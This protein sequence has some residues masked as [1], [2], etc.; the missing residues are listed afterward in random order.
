MRRSK[1]AGFIVGAVA[2]LSG[3]AALGSAVGTAQASAAGAARTCRAWT[4]DHPPYAVWLS[5]VD[6]L[7]PCDI[8]ATGIPGVNTQSA[9]VTDLLHWNGVTWTLR[10]SP[11]V[12]ASLDPPPAVTATSDRDV[13]I[14]GTGVDSVGSVQ[15]LIAHWNGT[16]LSRAASPNPGVPPGGLLSGV[17][18]AGPDDAWAVGLYSV[19]STDDGVYETSQTYPLAA[20]W[21]GR[22]WTQV[23]AAQPG[24]GNGNPSPLAEFNAVTTVGGSDAWAVGSDWVESTPVPNER[25]VPLAERWN[26]RAWQVLSPT[27]ADAHENQL[28]A[29]SAAGPND[30]W[31]VGRYGDQGKT[32]TEHWNGVRWTILPSPSPGR[33]DGKPEGVLVGVAVVSARDAWAVGSYANSPSVG[34][35]LALVLHWNGSSWRQVA[36]PHYGPKGSPNLLTAV[37]ASSSGNV[38]AVGYYSGP[39]GDGQQALVLR[40]P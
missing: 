40:L 11:A 27:P 10:T 1:A 34:K 13:W 7:S 25:Q 4:G 33:V 16:A 38:I 21:N 23:A 28:L 39:V 32:L 5:G 26:G 30:V 22:A 19:Y 31:A 29:V 12:P 9:T 8:W 37:S 17:S 6:V 18:A 36:V 24:A 35:P 2:A 3:L 15:T 14:A 20:H